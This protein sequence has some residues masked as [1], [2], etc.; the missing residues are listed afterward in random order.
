MWDQL[1]KIPAIIHVQNILPCLDLNSIVRL[2]TALGNSERIQTLRSFLF[3]FTIVNVE[4]YINQDLAKLKWLQ[5]HNFPIRKAIVNL[6]K[7]NSTFE[8]KLIHEIELVGPAQQ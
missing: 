7:I 4:V 6:N 2:E 1:K 3:R 8:T 5:A